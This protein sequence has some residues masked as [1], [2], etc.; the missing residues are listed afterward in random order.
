MGTAKDVDYTIPDECV[1]NTA[2]THEEEYMCAKK[3]QLG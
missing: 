2:T 1:K 3:C